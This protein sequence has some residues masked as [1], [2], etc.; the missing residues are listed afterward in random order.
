MIFVYLYIEVIFPRFPDVQERALKLWKET[1]DR[2]KVV[3]AVRQ[4]KDV[5]QLFMQWK[6]ALNKK[7]QPQTE[8]IEKFLWLM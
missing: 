6:V 8:E 4:Y 1:L 3:Q 2:R 5:E 7:L